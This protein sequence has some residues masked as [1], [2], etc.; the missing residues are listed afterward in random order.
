MHRSPDGCMHP[1]E[2]PTPQTQGSEM[3]NYIVLINWTDQGARNYRDT[4]DR[5]EQARRAA[6]EL[7]VRY[8]AAY[9]TLGQYDLLTM[10]E[11]PDDETLT[12]ALL[13]AAGAGNIRTT[14]LRA[15][16]ADEMRAIL[17]KS[18]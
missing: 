9:W 2:Q 10:I 11:A 18:G 6:E 8:T 1:S 17:A 7:G 16:D 4:L 14:T 5:Y 15:F 3:A 13:A 12:A